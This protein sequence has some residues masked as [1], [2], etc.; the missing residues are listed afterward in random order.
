M[1]RPVCC[2]CAKEMKVE[3]NGVWIVHFNDNERKKGI[4]EMRCGDMFKCE[5]C[6]NTVVINYGDN[7]LGKDMFKSDTEKYE[8]FSNNPA[9]EVKR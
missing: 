8:F 6:G 9:M 1:I 2:V 4:D 7:V 5:Q 3:Q